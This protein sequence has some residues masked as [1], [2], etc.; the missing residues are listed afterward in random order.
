MKNSTQILIICA[1]ITLILS[2]SISSAK[3]S[4]T[5]EWTTFRYDPN[6]SGT[7]DSN[8]QTNY[9]KQIWNFT[10]SAAIV[11]SPAVA[12]G[13]VFFGSR[14]YTIYCLDASNGQLVWNFSTAGAVDSSPAI[15]DG[16]V[17]VGSDDGWFYCINISSGM[18]V[19][20][21]LV[22]G[23]TLSSPVVVDDTV[24]V[25][26]GKQGFY[27]FNATNGNLV[28]KFPISFRVDSSPAVNE[29]VVY[30]SA[31]DFCVYALNATTGQQIWKQHTGST[32]SSPS[33]DGSSV[34]VGSID[35]YVCALN[36][37]DG[38]KIWQY[39]LEDVVDSSPAVSLQRIYVGADDN[40]LYCLNSSS[41]QKIW[42]TNAGYWIRS[43]PVVIGDRVFVGSEDHHLY[44]FNATDGAKIWSLQTRNSVDSSPAVVNGVLYVGSN[45]GTLYA[46][47]LDQ[48]NPEPTTQNS[49]FWTTLT[50]DALT[51][52][53]LVAIMVYAVRQTRAT[54]PKATPASNNRSKRKWFMRHID[55]V[56]VL[57]LLGFSAIFFVD[58][59]KGPLWIADEQTYSQWAYNMLS[60]G[61]YFAPHAFGGLAIWIGKPPLFMWLISFAFQAFGVNN[62]AAR[63]PSA[64][65]AALSLVLVYYLGKSLNNRPVGFL[66]ALILGTFSTFYLFARHAMTDVTFTFFI[67]ASVYFFV[68]SQKT[69]KPTRYVLLSGIFF[70]L[71]LL[72]KQVEALLL[73]LIIITYLLAT[74]R[75][76]KFLFT[77]GFALFWGVGVLMVT[78]WIAFMLLS[79]K[80]DFWNWFVV[81]CGIQRTISPIEGHA[82]NYLFYFSYLTSKETLWAI[83]LPFAGAL[84][85]FNAAVRHIKQDALLLSWMG[86]VLLV[87]TVAQTK[88]AWYILP[89]FPAFAIA[90]SSLLY[91]IAKQLRNW[92]RP[93]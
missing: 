12:D 7:T 73:P 16:R 89:A 79:F 4:T 70:G 88:L 59:S 38:K 72:T 91:Q 15:A 44:C 55:L 20:I 85:I 63:L 23:K 1:L 83:F 30:F 10:T 45:D 43:S 82:G 61:D 90:I 48:Q 87:F 40:N 78:P 84:C 66:A 69:Q 49:P 33:I 26:S 50:F 76:A 53:L 29:G 11:S 52:L 21:S 65:F 86:I 2:C 34:F 56:A 3:C 58:L 51:C 68:Q 18:P 36:S 64:V 47:T 71:A 17:F 22:G 74:K 41:G 54:K 32:I 93:Q 14:D 39:K 75:S 24:F 13:L 27:C 35:G 19:W 80:T 9:P 42:N 60:T 46:F 67:V 8:T 81:Y 25:G 92:T 57:L 6:H 28:W 5:N 77:K 31:D 62:F 37:S